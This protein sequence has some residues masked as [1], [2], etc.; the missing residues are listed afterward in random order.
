[1]G[2]ELKELK[3]ENEVLTLKKSKERNRPMH[4]GNCKIVEYPLS[5]LRRERGMS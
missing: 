2:E 4:M 3:I 1:M 5:Q